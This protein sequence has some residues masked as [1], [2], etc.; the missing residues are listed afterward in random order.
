MSYRH[1]E[2]KSWFIQERQDRKLDLLEYIA[3]NSNS[4]LSIDRL[5]G[6]FSWAWGLRAAKIYEYLEELSLADLISI[7]KNTVKLTEL[8]KKLLEE[9]KVA[10]ARRR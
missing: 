5:V 9:G 8:G 1:W 6:A 7:E 4:P 10:R 3:E 2:T